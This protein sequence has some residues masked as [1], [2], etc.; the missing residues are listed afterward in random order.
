MNVSAPIIRRPKAY[1]TPC[2]SNFLHLRNPWLIAWWSLC[3]P[4]F[5]HLALGT[6]AKGIFLFVGEMLINYM[7]KINLAILY[8]FTGKIQMAKDILDTRWLLLYCGFLVF[9]VWDSYRMAVEINKTSILADREDAPI[10]PTNI[11]LVSINVLV[12]RNPWVSMAWSVLAPG[13][14][15]LYNI[16]T[17]KAIFLLIVEGSI[18]VLSHALQAIHLTALG[19]FQQA[20]NILDWQ[21]FLNIPSFYVFTMW[22]SYSNTIEINKIFEMEQAQ[23]FR[24]NF[25]DPGFEYPIS[26]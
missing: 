16:Q 14:G 7:G 24:N 2:G 1:M 5:G 26:G 23:Y 6:M 18:I 19:D 25:Q 21:W 20:K 13:M 3:Y 15:Q 12:K 17:A 4:G 8:S 22:E 10:M 11:G 9:A